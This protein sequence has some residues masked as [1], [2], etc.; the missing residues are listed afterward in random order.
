MKQPIAL[1]ASEINNNS[2]LPNTISSPLLFLF[3]DSLG[4]AVQFIGLS[5]PLMIVMLA[6][7]LYMIVPCRWRSGNPSVYTRCRRVGLSPVVMNHRG[8]GAKFHPLYIPRRPRPA[9][10]Q[11]ESF[12]LH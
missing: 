7:T 11:N 10:Q 2:L 6:F 5:L 9:A 12:H 3:A 8:V 1:T 4:Q